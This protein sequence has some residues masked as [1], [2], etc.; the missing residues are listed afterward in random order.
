MIFRAP[1]MLWNI[2]MVNEPVIRWLVGGPSRNGKT[3]LVR[4]LDESG[5]LASLPVE[6]LFT[7]YL[8]A[9]FSNPTAAV[10]DYLQ[11]PRWTDPAR[12]VAM[13]PADCFIVPAE[14]I[15]R[16]T[17][18][19]TRPLQA[20]AGALDVMAQERGR[21]GWI[22]CDLLPETRWRELRREIPGLRLLVVLR[23]PRAACCA[24]LY[25]RSYPER[26][27]DATTTLEFAAFQWSL[28]ARTAFGLQ[29]QH[30]DE[31]EVVC[32]DDL[33]ARQPDTLRNIS[34]LLRADS[35]R[36][37]AALPRQPWFSRIGDGF[38][39]PDG[40]VAPLLSSQ[41]LNLI[42]SIAWPWMARLNL[43]CS[44]SRLPAPMRA[45]VLLVLAKVSPELARMLGQWHYRPKLA[46]RGAINLVRNWI[47]R[48]FHI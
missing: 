41:E 1:E 16:N 10:L 7:V 11:R 19:N 9:R 13:T 39:T 40:S 31:V 45:R 47:R 14:T 3:T 2:D 21:P 20:I 17:A 44:E 29:S 28:A 27:P 33:I 15:A 34:T 32:F 8:D 22:T 24:S 36:L 25:W 18:S 5:A 12:T 26:D 46:M 38:L 6:A 43:S 42:E 37:A 4:A 30:P 23:D 35:E 48:T